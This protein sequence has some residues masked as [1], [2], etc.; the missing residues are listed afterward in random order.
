MDELIPEFLNYYDSSITKFKELIDYPSKKYLV[1]IAVNP[2]TDGTIFFEGKENF[3]LD[4]FFIGSYF[5]NEEIW[6]WNWV[7]PIPK[8]NI[9]LGNE[10]INY[11]LNFDEEKL[12]RTD[13][14]FIRSILVNSRLKIKK[15]FNLDILFGLIM[16]ITNVKVLI[17][18]KD[19]LNKNVIRYFG[20]KNPENRKY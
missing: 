1:D 12:D 16:F 10:L 9:Q 5:T 14:S 2:K 11:A 15:D 8:K 18:I 3:Y 7:H 19:K 4:C 20:I 13:F 17:P 6:I